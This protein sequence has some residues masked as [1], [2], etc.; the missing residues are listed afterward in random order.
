MIK[1]PMKGPQAT[2]LT[3]IK[4]P[5]I[6]FP[7]ID[8]FRCIL[9]T[10]PMTSRLSPFPNKHFMK[11]ASGLLDCG[12]LLDGE[13]VCGS[14]KK[15]GVLGRTSSGLTTR[16]GEPD[17]TLWVFDAP[18][19]GFF[20][21]RFLEATQIVK[22]LDHPRIKI[23]KGRIIENLPS[24]NRFIEEC[25]AKGYEGVITRNP[26]GFY[27]QGKSTLREQ[28]M[29]KIK[30]FEDAEGRVTGYFEEEKNNNEAK[31]EITGKLKRSSAKAGKVGKGRLG[32]LI[33]ED[34]KSGVEVRVGGG[35]TQQERIN[36]WPIRKSLLGK[37]VKYKKQQVGEKDKPRHPGFR[38][39]IGWRP[40]WDL[41]E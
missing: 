32:G 21:V 38:E 9:G 26:E 17:W 7:K 31:R 29:L 30:P 41:A 18:S 11:E 15:K 1:R 28:G 39:F 16:E 25:L 14:K 37:L 24:L 2:D 27:K 35:F 36:L 10:E 12:A 34:V 6:A 22:D 23:L 8:G 3:I 13:I 19:V 5:V 33:L 40:D 20:R 4:F